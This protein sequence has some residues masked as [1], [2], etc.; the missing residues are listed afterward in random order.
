MLKNWILSLLAGMVWMT[1]PAAGPAALYEQRGAQRLV[2]LLQQAVRFPTVAGNTE[3]FAAQK[4]WLMKTAADMGF[5]VREAQGVVEITLP[6]PEGGSLLGLATHGDVVPVDPS[7]WSFD[8]FSGSVEGGYI[9]G[10]GTADDKCAIVQALLAMQAVAESGLQRRHGIRLL[11]G[12]AEETGSED[13]QAYVKANPAPACSLVLD[14][15]FPVTFGEKASNTLRIVS[16]SPA[17]PGGALRVVGMKAGLFPSIVPDDAA[18]EL[19]GEARALGQLRKLLHHPAPGTRLVVRR[20]GGR[21]V[22]QVLG[23]ASHS[24]MNLTGGR[25][26]ITSLAQVLDGL[27]PEGPAAELLAFARMAGQDLH[28]A[29]LGLDPKAWA[30]WG[31]YG[32]NVA[33]LRALEDG[34]FELAV[35]LRRP[36]EMGKD[37]MRTHLEGVIAR[38]NQERGTTLRATAF[39]GNEPKVYGEAPIIARLAGLYREATGKAAAPVVMGGGTYAK[40]LPN[41]I[42]FGMWFSE[43]PYPGHGANE[44]VLIADLHEGVKVLTHAL[45]A[46]VTS[47]TLPGAEDFAGARAGGM[48]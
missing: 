37:A 45:E 31:G 3:A 36:P 25:N 46:L 42:A 19:E 2:P 35:N 18:V 24:G 47:A 7:K 26:A 11:V 14:A 23:K 44:K 34:R 29:G 6:A 5:E 39:T 48:K 32:V 16:D 1:L 30:A 4:T 40:Y 27:L 13:M 22:V 12:S 10:R 38:F 43:K 21:M 17:R 20:Q 41:A 33:E 8:P 9:L 15:F 28:G